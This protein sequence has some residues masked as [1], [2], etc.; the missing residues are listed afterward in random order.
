MNSKKNDFYGKGWKFPP[1]FDKKEGKTDM[2]E[3]EIDIQQSLEILMS[4]ELGERVMQPK[5]GTELS[6]YVFQI[7][8]DVIGRIISKSLKAKI[9]VYE[10][11]IKVDKILVDSTRFLDGVL[12]VNIQFTVRQTN[13]RRNIVYPFYLGEGTLIP[14]HLI[15]HKK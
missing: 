9:I 7:G 12:A 14:E 10:P 11:R 2:V 4:T 3:G 6:S 5:Y 15:H 8:K 1:S 13:N